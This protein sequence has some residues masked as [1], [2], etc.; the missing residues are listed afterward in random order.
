MLLSCVLLR[1][2]KGVYRCHCPGVTSGPGEKTG[3]EA[4][5]K[6][7]IRV[8]FSGYQ[9]TFHCGNVDIQPVCQNAHWTVFEI[10]L[11]QLTIVPTTSTAHLPPSPWECNT[12]SVNSWHKQSPGPCSS[13]APTKP[14]YWLLSVV[15]CCSIFRAWPLPLA[16]WQL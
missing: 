4:T 8:P 16:M 12:G 6:L 13:S 15:P 11:S 14:L 9:N 10:L 1:K 3:E 2:K 5:P 7:A